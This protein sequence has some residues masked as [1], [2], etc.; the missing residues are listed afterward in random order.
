ML[1]KRRFALLLLVLLALAGTAVAA[2]DAA[3]PA[4]G[5][6]TQ[7]PP[8][9]P[10]TEWLLLGPAPAPLPAFHDDKVKGFAAADLVGA[11]ALDPLHLE[12]HAAD[13]VTLPGAGL[14]AWRPSPGGR[15]TLARQ[16]DDLPSIAWLATRLECDR[17]LAAPLTLVTAHPVGAWLDGRPLTLAA[18]P[19]DTTK[20]RRTAPLK[21]TPGKHL[22][23]ICTVAD[24]AVK[25]EWSVA[26]EIAPGAGVPADAVDVS[27]AALRAQTVRDVL[28]APTITGTVIS[29][30][31]RL[32]ALTLTETGPGG[33]RETWVE[34]RRAADGRLERTWRGVSAMG[35]VR[36]A[37]TGSRLSY[38]SD[39]DD[40]TTIWLLDLA[41]DETAPLLRDVE[42]LTNYAWSPDGTFLVCQQMTKAEPD[43]RRIRRFENLADRQPDW[44]DRTH[45]LQ[46]SVPDGATRRLT[47]GEWSADNWRISP[48]GKRLLFFR[49]WPDYSAR[50]YIHRELWELD[51][52]T[53]AAGNILTD[54]WLESAEYGPDPQMLALQGSPSAFNG[55]GR[56]L[57][58]GIA[59]ND[60]GGQLYLYDRRTGTPTPV[61]RDFT[62]DLVRMTWNRKD[63]RIYALVVD[64]QRQDLWA[65]DPAARKWS[66]LDAA[67][68]LM[69]D[70]DLALDA[71]L[72]IALGSSATQPQRLA[73]VDLKRGLSRVIVEP[74][75]G[76]YRD[77]RVG[78]V[79]DWQAKLPSGEMLDG[80]VYYPLDYDPA[81][82]YPCIVYYYGGTTPVG[83]D[84][85]GRYPK[86][87]WAGLGYFVYVPQPS[88]AI[89]YGQAF[90]AR[91]VNDWGIRTAQEVIDGTQA[92]LAAHPS[93]D[94]T[95]LACIGASYGGFLTEYLLTRT[96]MF[97]C[98]ISH[99]GISSIAGYWGE[100]YWGYDYG[101]RALA[102][103]FP[104]SNRDLYVNQSALFNADR[105]HTPLLLLHG[106]ADTNVPPGE[107]DQLY[108]ALKLLGREVEYVRIEGQNHHIIDRDQ[109][110]L[111][112]D[113]ILAWFAKWLKN[114]PQWWQELYQQ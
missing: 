56:D 9:F 3:A 87:V 6:T 78:R 23:L 26:A 13:T 96:D 8:P 57:A 51:L 21:L 5:D 106:S 14:Y 27:T 91:H 43:K 2:V 68:E 24:P 39:A 15:T 18:V 12:P 84:F 47:A 93:V 58:A 80:R 32:V 65:F 70:F 77:I 113:T 99:A 74:S 89:G 108:T 34:L 100:G 55:L 19:G 97:A 16:T 38:T 86:N 41:T 111:W 33:R 66:R 107:S 81:Q 59:A 69:D 7:A 63:G 48:D 73:L 83:R 95:K 28:D 35:N 98:G 20:T 64:G 29:P 49:E 90:A 104:W 114:E 45:L 25:G 50:P 31:G 82:Q 76:Y 88:G 22:L 54:P 4:P 36:W 102:D 11:D 72:G 52:T 46:V 75:A 92:F 44:R 42:N 101:A 40:R 112:N 67:M 109:R 105:I 103:A 30:D 94:R 71:P 53:L 1:L 17:W 85:G 60:Y 61:S 110:I 10:L 62:P 79:E 37:P